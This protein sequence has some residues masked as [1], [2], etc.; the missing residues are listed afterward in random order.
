MKAFFFAPILPPPP[1]PNEREK[2]KKMKKIN[3]GNGVLFNKM[4]LRR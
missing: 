3:F 4:T 2:W 1:L